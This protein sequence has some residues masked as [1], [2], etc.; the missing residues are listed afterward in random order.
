MSKPEV[1]IENWWIAGN[2]LR[3]NVF[4]HPRFP[5]D[6]PVTTS[7]ILEV[8]ML[9]EEGDVVVSAIG[10]GIGLKLQPNFAGW[11]MGYPPNW[12]DLNSPKPSTAASN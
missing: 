8:P 12:T 9:P 10:S 4:G 1:K 6:T 11:M 2:V 5:D 7:S 3:G